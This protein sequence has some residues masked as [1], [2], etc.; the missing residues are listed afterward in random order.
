MAKLLPEAP[1]SARVAPMNRDAILRAITTYLRRNPQEVARAIRSLVGLRV[2]VP[3]DAFRWLGSQAATTGKAEDVE[4]DAVPPG[5]RVAA[6]IHQMKTAIRA[7]A[8]I[9]IERM[10]V[11]GEEMRVEVRLERVNLDVLGESDSPVAVLIKSGALDLS[12]PGNLVKHL[13]QRPPFLVDAADNRI[14]ID[15]MKHP[16]IGGTPVVR[17]AISVVTSFV[18]IHGVETDEEHLDV[19]LRALPSG[20]VHA[21]R[22][23]RRHVLMP[24]VR[25]A[26]HFL[27][28]AHRA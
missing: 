10:V 20:V 23:W 4:V 2:G 27:P 7:S 28:R 8:I 25:R 14:V 22:Q 9:Y 15:L 19:R 24:G 5:V 17:N 3:M 12:K 6:T 16:K 13:P 1:L 18:T 21:A 26:R 11:S